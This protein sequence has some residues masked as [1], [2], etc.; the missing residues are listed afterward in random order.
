MSPLLFSLALLPLPGLLK[1]IE[2]ED[3]AFYADVITM[4]MARAGSDVWTE[5][6][7]QWAANTVQECA[8]SC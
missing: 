7:L 3:H 6:A 5:E 4:W 2:G 1:Q 8:K